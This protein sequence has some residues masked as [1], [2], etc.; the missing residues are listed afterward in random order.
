[1][2]I[3][4][5]RLQNVKCFEDIFL[6]FRTKEQT[7]DPQ[8]NWNVILGHNGDGKTTLLQ[9]IAAYL[10]DATTADRLLKPANW[11]R[12]DREG[13][14]L[15]AT[16]H[17]SADDKVGQRPRHSDLS[18][19]EVW[20][21]ILR[22]GMDVP[23]SFKEKQEFRVRFFPT[24]TVVDLS[25]GIPARFN[26]DGV[27]WA[28]LQAD[29]EF[30]RRW[31]YSDRAHAGWISAGYGAFRR[32]SGFASET[33]SV[34]EPLQRRFLTLFEEG[35]AL[36]DYEAWLRELDRR[37]SRRG[38]DAAERR[39]LGT[40]KEAL[41]QLLPD[42]ESIEIDDEVVFHGRSGRVGLGQL[43]DGY[44][45]MFALAADL[46]RWLKA[47]HRHTVPLR[48]AS[49][50]VLIDEI[51]AHLHPRWQR[52]AGFLLTRVFPNI[53]F[54]VTS[55]SPFVAMA[56]GEGAL[57]LLEKDVDSVHARQDVPYVRGWAVDQ[58]LTELFGLVSLRDPK[59]TEKL[60]LYENL[61]LKR[62]TAGLRRRR[63]EHCAGSKP[64]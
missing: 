56:A 18:A 64:N 35:A 16:L 39:T 8:S 50:I 49:G 33:V 59:T 30:L 47:L 57:T 27:E 21:A 6:E 1:M 53:Q 19:R 20:Y 11:I 58:V 22:G 44:R 28:R 12:G 45:S 3:E 4:S 34:T 38:K 24:T 29:M 42:V 51:D 36:Y 55:H 31:A 17:P 46:L 37:A 43:S 26:T 5:L 60:D 9:S 40:V 25:L 10:M 54:I 7:E 62:R 23:L 32:V 48:E 52:E 61:R 15:S 13:A 14:W 63:R 2:Y 41:R